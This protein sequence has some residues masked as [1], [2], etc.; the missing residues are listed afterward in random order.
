[1]RETILPVF[2]A[3]GKVANILS[4]LEDI[5]EQKKAAD[6][7]EESEARYRML[8]DSIRDGVVVHGIRED[9]TPDNFLEVN[10]RFCEMIGYSRP[11]LL[12]KG[13]HGVIDSEHME[14]ADQLRAQLKNGVPDSFQRVLI[15]K[16]GRRIP[17]EVN[18]FSLE[19]GGRQVILSV[20]RDTTFRQEAEKRIRSSLAEKETLL[21]EIHHR[22]KNN[23]Q[24]ISGLLNLQSHYIDD[25]SVRS[26]YKESQNRIK[27]MALIHEELYQRDDLAR[28][29][30]AEYVRDLTQN[31]L[32]SYMV[33]KG[34][35]ELVLD[36]PD[37]ELNLDTAIPCGLIV[38]ELV[39]NALKHAF[40]EEVAGKIAVSVA[41]DGEVYSLVISDNGKGFPEGVDFRKV[42]SMGMQLVTVL[43]EQLGGNVQYSGTSGST[44]T[45][46][47]KEYQESGTEVH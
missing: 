1:L 41:R 4:V 13:P 26:I 31:L 39:S 38:N 44:F 19:M 6:A 17:C 34:S 36:I 2:G 40:T 43:A 37:M 28:I 22:V 8:F 23:L 29:N 47:F 12:K 11:E 7:L 9:N 3:D 10:S 32:A 16:D 30:L 42:K 35:V 46:T 14:G 27:T 45:V 15:T 24:V 33:K 21:K 25:E 18:A 20:V 5:T